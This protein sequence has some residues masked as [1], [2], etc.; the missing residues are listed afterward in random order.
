MATQ[1]SNRHFRYALLVLTALFTSNAQ[2]GSIYAYGRLTG[3]PTSLN[4]NATKDL[5]STAIGVPVTDSTETIAV[6]ILNLTPSSRVKISNIQAT[7]D[8]SVTGGTCINPNTEF[9][10]SDTCTLDIRF[11]PTALGIRNGTLNITCQLVAV[12]VGLTT[13]ACDNSSYIAYNLKGTGLASAMARAIPAL[14][15]EATT[16]LALLLLITTLLGLRRK[17]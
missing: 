12:S 5:G 13:L 3:T 8:F 17:S 9:Q 1:K 15:R 11:S 16:L 2:G 14:G 10:H 4:D 7:G 6:E